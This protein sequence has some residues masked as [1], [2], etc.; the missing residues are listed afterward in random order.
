MGGGAKTTWGR[1]TSSRGRTSGGCAVPLTVGAE[2]AQGGFG[3][4]G[5]PSTASARS[6]GQVT[7]CEEHC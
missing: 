1:E 4:I 3:L 6:R 2:V 7:A 5:R